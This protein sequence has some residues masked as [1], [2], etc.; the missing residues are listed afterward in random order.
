MKLIPALG[1]L[2]FA[3]IVH[4]QDLPSRPDAQKTNDLMTSNA[5]GQPVQE[6]ISDNT[7]IPDGVISKVYAQPLPDKPVPDAKLGDYILVG[8]P[9]GRF[10][11]DLVLVER[12]E[13]GRLI[14]H[15]EKAGTCFWCGRP[16]TW[17]QAAFDKKSSSMWA[18]RTG[19]MVADIELSHHAPCFAAGA[20]REG[21]PLLGQTRAQ[22]YAVAGAITAL[23]WLGVAWLRKGDRQYHIGGSKYWWIPPMV[24]QATSAVGIIANLARWNRR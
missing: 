20:C 6:L 3:A 13:D 10:S 14:W 2:L 11:D 19:L 16:M 21:N 1:F 23:D 24:G 22:A 17:R 5:I 18:L 4:A 7:P 12:K 15:V 9:M 8:Q